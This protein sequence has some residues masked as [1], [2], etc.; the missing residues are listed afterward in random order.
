MAW[1]LWVSLGLCCSRLAIEGHARDVGQNALRGSPNLW[2]FIA[3]WYV[4][5]CEAL[6]SALHRLDDS[7]EVR[8]VDL[9]EP[10]YAVKALEASSIESMT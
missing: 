1:I 5:F 10:P 2:D 9:M 6:A 7:V 8:V 4:Q 3:F